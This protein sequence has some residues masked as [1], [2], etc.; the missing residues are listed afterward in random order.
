MSAY[1]PKIF[2]SK[3]IRSAQGL[4]SGHP[5]GDALRHWVGRPHWTKG[6]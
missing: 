3:T 1:T 4:L 2:V 5:L 6:Q